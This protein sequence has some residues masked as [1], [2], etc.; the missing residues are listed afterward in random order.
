MSDSPIDSSDPS[1]MQEKTYSLEFR[2]KAGEY[3]KI[4][5]VNVLLTVV[6]LGIYSA[7]AKVR[8]RKYF[9]KNTILDGASLDY[10]ADPI[11]ILKG[12]IILGILFLAYSVG[13]QFNP[14]IGI[15]AGLLFA[16]LFPWI[17]VRG[18]IFNFRNTSYRNLRF[19][20]Q[21]DYKK[22]YL[23]YLESFFVSLLSLGLA[24]PYGLYRHTDFIM[25]HVSYG[26]ASGKYAGRPGPW[27]GA[28]YLSIGIIVL[29]SVVGVAIVGLL[30][31]VLGPLTMVIAPVFIYGGMAVASGILKASLTN[32]MARDLSIGDVKFRGK[33]EARAMAGI[34]F[35]NLL[36]VI[37]SFGLATP[38]ALHRTRK[39]RIEHLELIAPNGNYLQQITGDAQAAEGSVADAAVDFW[40]IDLGF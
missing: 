25:N 12:R 24:Y 20:F 2:G 17:V 11:K 28:I 7:W 32:L 40:D 34:Y 19:N 36:A 1:L 33:L 8:T 21:K 27:F 30:N 38:W 18:A 35:V 37:S 6:T 39:Y 9:Y 22:S 10:H 14:F 15:A 4:W 16:L 26:K 23:T 29:F 5:I 13:P 3:F 31:S